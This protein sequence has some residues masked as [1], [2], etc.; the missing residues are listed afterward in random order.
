MIVCYSGPA[1]DWADLISHCLRSSRAARHYLAEEILNKHSN[2]FQ[3]YLIDCPSAEV[4]GNPQDL[5]FRKF[6]WKNLHRFVVPSV[7]Y[8]SLLP[9]VLVKMIKISIVYPVYD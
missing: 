9:P 2:R 3:E 8:L 7:E 5:F 6:Y 4:S 1:G